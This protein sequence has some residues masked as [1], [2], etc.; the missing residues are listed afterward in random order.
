MIA[1]RSKT[2]MKRT[3]PLA[4][5]RKWL[6]HATLMLPAFSL[7]VSPSLNATMIVVIQAKD[8]V[9]IGADSVRSSGELVC[10]VHQS[11]FGIV[12]KDGLIEGFDK[13]GQHYS[14]DKEIHDFV[15]STYSAEEFRSS[16]R[17]RY[18]AD[19]WA[20]VAYLVS[21]PEAAPESLESETWGTAVP[22]ITKEM[23]QR[24]L[25][26][27]SSEGGNIKVQQLL[28]NP[29]SRPGPFG[30]FRYFVSAGSGQHASSPPDWETI[31]SEKQ[32]RPQDMTHSSL[33]QFG[34]WIDY[35]RDDSWIQS[36]PKEAV[37]EVLQQAATQFKGDVG[38][39]YAVLHVRPTS[40]SNK[41][42]SIQWISRGKCPSWTYTV[43]NDPDLTT[44]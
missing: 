10:K 23:E 36:N 5:T 20:Q 2:T 15:N 30:G 8:G 31:K 35:P 26:L 6:A 1:M 4:K 11:S 32:L 44:K 33:L 18:I 12:A 17:D 3:T 41:P 40:K 21:Q 16:I 39:P 27:V 7:A 29:N 22:K 28:V 42:F 37:L 9:W 24:S 14:I 19:I 13:N 25:I 38:P 34:V 43:P